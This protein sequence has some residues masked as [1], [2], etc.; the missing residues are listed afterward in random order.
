MRITVEDLG[1]TLGQ[2]FREAV[3]DKK[4][5]PGMD[6]RMSL[7]MK[8]SRVVVDLSGRP[9]LIYR[10]LCS[11]DSRDFDVDCSR[12]L[13]GFTNHALSPTSII[14]AE[15]TRTTG[16]TVNL[17]RL[18]ERYGWRLPRP[19]NGKYSR[20]PKARSECFRVPAIDLGMATS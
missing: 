6:M 18:V 3:G 4:G 15:R 12:I 17:K 7:S 14:C 2:A 19:S 11:G 9:G 5:L 10:A 13:P 20:R 16:W 8:R 1:I